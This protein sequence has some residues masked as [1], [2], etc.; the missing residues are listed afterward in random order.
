MPHD[1]NCFMA[2]LRRAEHRAD[3]VKVAI[4][5]GLCIAVIGCATIGYAL[6]WIV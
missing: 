3:M 5:A 4:S 6:G 2:D 1:K